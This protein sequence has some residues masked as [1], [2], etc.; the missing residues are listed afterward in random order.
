MKSLNMISILYRLFL[1]SKYTSRSRVDYHTYII[2]MITATSSVL[3]EYTQL[4]P[5]WT[6]SPVIIKKW[7]IIYCKCT[8]NNSNYLEQVQ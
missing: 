2:R 6:E 1:T 7:F 8:L 3:L 4:L 5:F